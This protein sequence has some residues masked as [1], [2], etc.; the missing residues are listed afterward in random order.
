MLSELGI[1][2]KFNYEDV[3]NELKLTQSFNEYGKDGHKK[4]LSAWI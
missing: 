1:S 4:L 2:A 3:G